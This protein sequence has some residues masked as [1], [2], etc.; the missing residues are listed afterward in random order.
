MRLIIFDVDGTLA[1]FQSGVLLPGVTEWFAAH[2]QEQ[3]VALV[4]N[5]G[6][7]GLRLWMETNKFGQPEQYP[8]EE[9]A[10][11]HIAAVQAQLPVSTRA[12][13]CFAYQS[14]KSG[15]WSPLPDGT[16]END[17]EWNPQ[18]RKPRPGMLL[19]AVREAGC[20]RDTALMVGD[21]EEDRLAAESAGITFEWAATFF[22]RGQERKN[23]D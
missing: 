10:R 6:G 23:D 12:Y 4:S 5:Q 18:Y 1:D 15:Q 9:Q 14:K 19:Q 7:V 17:P 8:T 11:N 22:G 2:G 20:S 21:S 13:L 16:S 3:I